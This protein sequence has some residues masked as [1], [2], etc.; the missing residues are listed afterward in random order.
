MFMQIDLG[1]FVIGDHA[2][3]ATILGKKGPAK[4]YCSFAMQKQLIGKVLITNLGSIGH[5]KSVC[6]W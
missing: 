4:Q 1:F 5:G 6:C 3:I 2:F